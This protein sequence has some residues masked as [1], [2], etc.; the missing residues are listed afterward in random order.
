MKRALLTLAIGLALAVPAQG[1]PITITVQPK[2]TV[3][4][5]QMIKLGEIAAITGPREQA[6]L[7]KQIEIARAPLPGATRQI[8]C[9]WIKNRLE[10]ARF[11][12]KTV[13]IK[14]Q[15]IITLVSESQTVKGSDIV[16]AARR[17]IAG[18]FPQGE[19]SYSLA[20]T[21]TT[22][23]ATVPGGKVELTAEQPARDIE[24]G[25]QP[26]CVDVLIDGTLY[27]KKTV[28]LTIK[29]TGPVLVATQ[30]IRTRESLTSLNT[31]IEQREITI[32]TGKLVGAL[33]DET[34]IANQSISAGSVIL[35]DMVSP[36]PLVSKGDPV[37]V[38]V[39]SGA[40]RVVVKGTASND[41]ALGESV[42]VSIP[43]SPE[44]I[45]GTLT[46]PGLVEVKV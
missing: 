29:A 36:K 25:R 18:Q 38:L 13:T 8:T 2:A 31:R 7:L 30:P 12:M 39:T 26:V 1:A 5:I 33:P 21:E 35:A 28:A 32:A 23:D 17:F 15:A 40:V 20:A 16:E 24:P 10:C 22:T 42:R 4:A 6:E 46:Q 37:T 34:K 11:D 44:E 41:A 27:T 43:G 9:A 3:K 45:Q 19:I 14:S